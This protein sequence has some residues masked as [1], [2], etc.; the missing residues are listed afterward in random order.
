MTTGATAPGCR[1]DSVVVQHAAG[2]ECLYPRGGLLMALSTN[3]LGCGW[4]RRPLS[5]PQPLSL[6]T[7]GASHRN[8]DP[9]LPLCQRS[10]HWLEWPVATSHQ[11]FVE[12]EA[13]P[14]LN[15]DRFGRVHVLG[16]DKPIQ[17]A[18]VPQ[19]SSASIPPHLH[20]SG[21]ASGRVH[22]SSLASTFRASACRRRDVRR[23]HP[24]CGICRTPKRSLWDTRRSGAHPSP[25]ATAQD[26]DEAVEAWDRHSLG[27]L[28]ADPQ[29]E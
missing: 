26:L 4:L 6:G 5:H 3:F 19:G 8:Y 2:L 16:R 9:G 17:V 25:L 15:T 1:A 18:A 29:G 28:A 20:P 22:T 11:L 7:P 27:V 21:C 24:R 12:V 10:F 13:H 23:G 14:E